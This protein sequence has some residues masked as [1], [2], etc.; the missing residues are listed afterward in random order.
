MYLKNFKPLSKKGILFGTVLLVFAPFVIN[1][2]ILESKKVNYKNCIEYLQ[3]N[4]LYRNCT[5][6]N[7]DIWVTP[8]R[9]FDQDSSRWQN[10]LH[11]YNEF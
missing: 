4:N 10:D 2:I 1:R 8:G 9:S 6:Y 11:E 7:H 5:T 3:S